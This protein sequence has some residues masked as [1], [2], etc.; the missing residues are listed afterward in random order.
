MTK[1]KSSD[2]KALML[3]ALKSTRKLSDEQ[4]RDIRELPEYAQLDVPEKLHIEQ[5]YYGVLD[6]PSIKYNE[7]KR[8][9]ELKY[10]ASDD[11]AEIR[12]T[13]L[14]NIATT[15]SKTDNWYKWR[16][17]LY[18]ALL[19]FLISAVP[20]SE[21]FTT[22]ISPFQAVPSYRLQGL[23]EVSA[24]DIIGL[25]LIALCLLGWGLNA[26]SIN[27]HLNEASTAWTNALVQT[28]AYGNVAT[29]MVGIKNVILKLRQ[30]IKWRRF[31]NFS[32]PLGGFISILIISFSYYLNPPTPSDIGWIAAFALLGL[33]HALW[34]WRAI[35]VRHTTWRDPTVHIALMVARMQQ[36]YVE[37]KAGG[38]FGGGTGATSESSATK[39]DDPIEARGVRP[40]MSGTLDR[41]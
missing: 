21:Y 3:E 19:V 22:I 36:R 40:Q 25:T 12:R 4:I 37:N 9:Y 10:Y 41:S 7:E 11:V 34:L 24:T 30:F 32:I 15:R 8:Q 27:I 2:P 5:G 35:R 28:S 14:K 39:F 31:V 23:V 33:W 20:Y 38:R 26:M 17:G 29:Q 1:P 13:A 6:D 18:H 16:I